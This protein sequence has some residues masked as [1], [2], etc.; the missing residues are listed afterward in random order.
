MIDK[1]KHGL[2]QKIKFAKKITIERNML[3]IEPDCPVPHMYM[4]PFL[5]ARQ[6]N[7]SGSESVQPV[8]FNSQ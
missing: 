3:N 1:N 7:V 2:H 6:F 5:E 8:L 4:K